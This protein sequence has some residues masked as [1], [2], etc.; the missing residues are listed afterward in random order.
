MFLS[1]QL[2][3]ERYA[4]L[5]ICQKTALQKDRLCLS[6]KMFETEREAARLC[7]RL[8]LYSSWAPSSWEEVC[9]PFLSCS[10]SLGWGILVLGG[11]LLRGPAG[12]RPSRTFVL[13][14]AA[15]RTLT[16]SF[17]FECCSHCLALSLMMSL[18]PSVCCFPLGLLRAGTLVV[19]MRW[20]GASVN[21]QN[22]GR[23]WVM[24]SLRWNLRLETFCLGK[25]SQ[26]VYRGVTLG[27]AC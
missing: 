10:H 23:T 22:V 16:H 6:L 19:K 25:A 4:T 20:N 13:S 5:P 9:F 7:H 14:A 11:S 27:V 12:P 8:R 1:L 24:F 15:Q 3:R 17:L 21:P 26:V 2:T 18:S